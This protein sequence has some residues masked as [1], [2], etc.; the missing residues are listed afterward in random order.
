M[1]DEPVDAIVPSGQ[2]T[3]NEQVTDVFE[4]M[5]AR[6]VPDYTT[7]RALV[8]A[9]AQSFASLDP[10]PSVVDLGCS[11]GTAIEMLLEPLGPAATFHGIDTSAPMLA[12]AEDRFAACS[13]VSL[14]HLDLRHAYPAPTATVTLAV[15]TLQFVPIEHRQRV[16]RDIFRHTRPGG[17]VILVEK[18]LGATAG[19]DDMM[20]NAYLRMK[21]AHGYTTEQIDRK[22][23]SLEGVLV[24]LTAAWN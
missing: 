11:R 19:I 24:P 18:V 2:W 3:F 10:C 6:S 4:N 20:V 21:A 15:L 7:M 5:L 8:S 23:A 17:A 1:T 16:V 12:A 13:N 9:V 14:E 22:R